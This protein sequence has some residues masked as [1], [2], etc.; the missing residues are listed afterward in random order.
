MENFSFKGSLSTDDFE[1]RGHFGVAE[2]MVALE[3]C[4]GSG[5]AVRAVYVYHATTHGQKT[6]R[7]ASHD[8]G[9]ESKNKPLDTKTQ[10][11][12]IRR[13]SV[14]TVVASSRQ[15]APQ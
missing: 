3:T 8:K 14:A 2:S 12:V 5:C 9:W 10:R 4:K 7:M 11:L 1:L 6:N 15:A 13:I